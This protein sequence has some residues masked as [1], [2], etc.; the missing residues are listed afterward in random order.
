MAQTIRSAYGAWSKLNVGLRD[1]VSGLSAEDLLTRPSSDRWPIWATVGH[2]A[3][4]RV[5]WLCDFAGEPGKESTR[6]TDAAFDCPGDDDLVNVLGP[7][8]LAEALDSTYRII[9]RCL[10]TW[11]LDRLDDV[12][13]RP[14]W[15]PDWVHS[16]GSVLQRVFAHDAWHAGQVSLILGM[17]GLPQPDV[18]S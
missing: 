13:R 8:E 5:F 2:L 1:I 12:L 11:T 4:Q 7:K 18:W 3:C 14:E 15:G 17:A 9:D 10:D 6:F 16:R